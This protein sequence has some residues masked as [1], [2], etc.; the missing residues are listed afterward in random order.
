MPCSSSTTGKS[1]TGEEIARELVT[2]LSVGDGI[3]HTLV[4]CAMR[5]GASTNNVS[6]RT[7]NVLYCNIFDVTCFSHMLNRIGNHF[8]V[9]ILLEFIKWMG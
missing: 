6:M 4:L 7:L 3:N 5:D 8:Q 9:P 2:V 1:L